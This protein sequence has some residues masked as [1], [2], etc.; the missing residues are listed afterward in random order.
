MK[1][2]LITGANGMLGQDAQ[3][4]LK[5]SGF[6]IIPTD[7]EELD[8]TDKATV[9]SFFEN[10]QFDYVFHGAAYTN[11]DGAESNKELAFKIN[12][13]GTENLAEFCKKYN[14]VLIY[15]STDYVFDG[16][17]G[18]TYKPDD[19]TNPVN[20][21]GLSKL[22]GEEAV[23]NTCDAYYIARTSWLYGHHG[24]NFVETMIKLGNERDLLTVVDDQIGCPTWTHA[25]I[26][27]IL[28]LIK[29]EK[30]FGIYHVCGTGKTSWYRFTKKIFEFMDIKT[31]VEPVTTDKFPRP[32]QRP[33]FSAMENDKICPPWEESLQQYLKMRK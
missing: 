20:I 31:A 10:N 30:P 33:K 27:G 15:I 1:T 22:K 14:R 21:Y 19:Q 24:N 5:K 16:E 2:V 13:T 11:V 32:A 7:V 29:E 17:K 9:E 18:S 3:V 23:Q 8:I 28:T 12:A 4:L 25:L 6:N 26:N